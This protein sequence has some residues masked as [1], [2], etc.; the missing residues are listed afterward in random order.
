MTALLG[1]LEGARERWAL[2]RAGFDATGRLPSRAICDHDEAL[3]WIR[4][5]RGDA[6]HVPLLLDAAAARFRVL[7][8]TPWIASAEALRASLSAPAKAPPDGLYAREVE[9]LALLAQGLANKE[10]AA[11]LF[12]SVPTV[13][14]HVA[15]VY[16]KIGARG[17]AAA[18]AYALR[19][20]L[21]PR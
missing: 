2:A 18:T 3:A 14:R 9:V 11:R 20:G 4:A 13:E 21:V 10:I 5:G 16:A 17:R 6:P 1:D 15:N 12:I 19:Q 8:M 7:G